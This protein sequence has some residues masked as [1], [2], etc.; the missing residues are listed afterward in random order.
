V[1]AIAGGGGKS[2]ND[3]IARANAL[4]SQDAPG[5]RAAE[6]S[7]NVAQ[8]ARLSGQLLSSVEALGTPSLN[9]NLWQQ[10]LSGEQ[11]AQ[12]LLDSG[13]VQGALAEAQQLAPLAQQLG[14]PACA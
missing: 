12:N 9:A 3:V 1:V 10:W 7:G 13:D 4:C 14:V 11:Q 5:I 2:K 8:V 6:A